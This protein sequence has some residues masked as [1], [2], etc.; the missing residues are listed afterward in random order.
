MRSFITL[1][2]MKYCWGHQIR[3]Y[4]VLGMSVTHLEFRRDYRSS[5]GKYGERDLYIDYGIIL[6]E[7]LGRT[8]RLISFDTTRTTQKTKNL[9]REY[10]DTHRNRHVAISQLSFYFQNKKSRLKIEKT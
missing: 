2:F 9:W 3:V 5:V 10:T 6:Q 4:E 8:N 7:V 1:P